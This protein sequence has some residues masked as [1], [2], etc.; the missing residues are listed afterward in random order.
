[1]SLWSNVRAPSIRL[2]E[3]ASADVDT[4]A[5]DDQRVFIDST[6]HHVSRKDAAAV[7]VDLEAIGQILDADPASP[8][9]GQW[10]ITDDGGT[11]ASIALKF[12]KGGV[13]Y[14]LAE[15]TL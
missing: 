8:V 9:N 14:T 11:P 13:T 12:R 7:V 5:T 15:V 4:P 10:W 3:Q 2:E 1:M 6:T